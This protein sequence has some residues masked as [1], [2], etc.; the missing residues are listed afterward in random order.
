[1]NPFD[2]P[3]VEAAKVQARQLTDEYRQSGK[4]PAGKSETINGDALDEFLKKASA[5][6]YVSLQVY[7]APNKELTEALQALRANLAGKY[8][9]ATTLGYGPRFLHSTGQLH[10]GDAGNGLFVQIVTQTPNEDIPIP[11]E[12]GTS[13]SEI[14]FGVLKRAQALGDAQALRAVGRR[15][16]S[17]EADRTQLISTINK[18]AAEF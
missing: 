2:Q 5:G 8:R 15:V 18:L 14:T 9:L 12:P 3:N 11:T 1:I 13:A 16:R 4:L 7:A 6:D 10:K 17:F